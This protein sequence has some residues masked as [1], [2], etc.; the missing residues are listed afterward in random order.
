MFPKRLFL[1]FSCLFAG[2]LPAQNNIGKILGLI[3]YSD[4]I[5][6][7][8]PK[9]AILKANEA[10][11]LSIELKNDSLEYKSRFS[12]AIAHYSTGNL[13]ISLE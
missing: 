6:H 2:L 3:H 12:K 9:E 8:D 5:V 4:S 13:N 10:L 11:K 1:F 7:F